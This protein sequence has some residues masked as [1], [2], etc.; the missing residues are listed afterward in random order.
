MDKIAAYEIALGMHEQEKRA[1]YL[2]DTY[3]TCQ[4]E[5]LSVYLQAFDQIEMEKDA[6]LGAIGRGITG[7]ATR[8]G[9]GISSSGSKAF[10]ANKGIPPIPNAPVIGARRQA[11]GGA[12]QQGAKTIF[13]DPNATKMLGGA[14]LATG[15]AGVIGGRM[16]K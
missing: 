10:A 3:G 15:G 13:K 8:L 16:S 6:F 7:L 2:V 5:M 1:E 4:G 14:A 12:I 11:I 9:R